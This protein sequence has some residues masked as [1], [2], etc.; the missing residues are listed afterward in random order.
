MFNLLA[1]E[2]PSYVIYI[3]LGVVEKKNAGNDVQSF[4]R[5]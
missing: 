2:M 3:V 1:A 4:R 5:R